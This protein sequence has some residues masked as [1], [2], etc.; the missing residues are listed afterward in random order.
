MT[1]GSLFSGIGGMDLG[2][3]RAGMECKWQ[4]EIDPFCQKVLEKHWPNVKRY[5]DI[6]QIDGSE[7]ERVDL[8]AGG[9]PCQDISIAGSGAGIDGP[10]SGLWSEY[11]RLISFLRPSGVLVE[12]VPAI[13]FRGI[14]RVLGDLAGI[15]YDA[16]WEIISASFFGA[17]HQRNRCFIFAYPNSSRKPQQKRIFRYEWGWTS[18]GTKAIADTM[19]KGF[20]GRGDGFEVKKNA[21]KVIQGDGS[22]EAFEISFSKDYWSI[23]P[24]LGRRIHGIPNRVDRIKSLGNAVVP[25]VAEWIGRRIMEAAVL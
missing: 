3:E 12:N 14:E 23:K 25:Q 24:F 22:T 9:F 6:K 20:S 15:G 19:R 18:N 5:G 13:L 2:L 11:F 16:Q 7:L 17:D 21:R 10:R 8:I 4:V 1:F